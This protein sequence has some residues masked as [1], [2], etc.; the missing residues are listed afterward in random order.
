MGAIRYPLPKVGARVFDEQCNEEKELVVINVYPGTRAGDHEIREHSR[1]TVAELNRQYDP[2][3][4]V[5]D[6]VYIE[7]INDIFGPYWNIRQLRSAA[8]CGSIRSYA[9]PASRLK[10]GEEG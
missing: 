7:D 2:G 9:F 3:E 1:H 6:A 8:Y 4:P 10:R 5:V